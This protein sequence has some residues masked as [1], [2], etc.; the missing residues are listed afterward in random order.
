MSFRC[1]DRLSDPTAFADANIAADADLVSLAE[2]EAAVAAQGDK[3]VDSR[4]AEKAR[5]LGVFSAS[6]RVTHAVLYLVPTSVSQEEVI[7]PAEMVFELSTVQTL[8]LKDSPPSWDDILAEGKKPLLQKLGRKLSSL[9]RLEYTNEGIKYSVIGAF[10]EPA[11]ISCS[12]PQD[13][14]EYQDDDEDEDLLQGATT[15]IRALPPKPVEPEVLLDSLV[16]PD[17]YIEPEVIGW[18]TPMPDDNT[19]AS[20]PGQLT[21]Q[22]SAV[23][24]DSPEPEQSSKPVASRAT[25]LRWVCPFHATQTKCGC[26]RK[27]LALK[28]SDLW[29]YVN[30]CEPAHVNRAEASEDDIVEVPLDISLRDTLSLP[31]AVHCGSDLRLR[32]VDCADDSLHCELHVA[33]SLLTTVLEEAIA[34]CGRS[35]TASGGLSPGNN[36]GVAVYAVSSHNTIDL[37]LTKHRALEDDLLTYLFASTHVDLF[38]SRKSKLLK[39]I[40]K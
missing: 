15:S 25:L 16:E 2:K 31:C 21:E 7:P 37:D 27:P 8:L 28:G 26:V 36:T 33:A 17:P 30:A 22:N 40:V 4:A 39:L 29:V 13:L 10:S 20:T 38:L 24:P 9:V 1:A 5:R 12:W 32:A 35:H 3:Y 34:H 18:S 6:Q 19:E 23:F 14:S 11:Y